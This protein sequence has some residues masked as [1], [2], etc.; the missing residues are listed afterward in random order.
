MVVP[1]DVVLEDVLLVHAQLFLRPGDFW[2]MHLMAKHRG[3]GHL[4]E[5]VGDEVAQLY[6]V[7]YVIEDGFAV[8]HLVQAV[9][10]LAYILG[11]ALV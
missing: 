8:I 3:R 9:L 4:P 10:Y 6:V 1:L 5:L 7:E 11:V 2:V